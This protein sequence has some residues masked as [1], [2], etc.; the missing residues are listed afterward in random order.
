MTDTKDIDYEQMLDVGLSMVRL[1]TL[2]TYLA[3]LVFRDGENPHDYVQSYI[4]DVIRETMREFEQDYY[5]FSIHG[6]KH[7]YSI[8]AKIE[9]LIESFYDWQEVY[10]AMELYDDDE[11]DE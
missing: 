1:G 2:Y 7:T 9:G 6:V 8:G 4:V 10:K 5:T 3:E 11:T